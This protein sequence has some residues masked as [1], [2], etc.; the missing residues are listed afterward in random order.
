MN[1]ISGDLEGRVCQRSLSAKQLTTLLSAAGY[2]IIF[3]YY[4]SIN[5]FTFLVFISMMQC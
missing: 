5:L 1:E 2:V 4:F 3:V